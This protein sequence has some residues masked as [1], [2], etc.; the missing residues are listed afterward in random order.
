MKTAAD[1]QAYLMKMELANEEPREGTYV[2]SGPL[3]IPD[4]AE[5]SIRFAGV[6]PKSFILGYFGG[7]GS[8]PDQLPRSGLIPD[9]VCGVCA[10]ITFCRAPNRPT[11]GPL[12]HTVDRPR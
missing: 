7:S 9:Q 12:A 8:Q 10:N 1:V 5:W 4:A 3:T 2:V 11:S 6:G